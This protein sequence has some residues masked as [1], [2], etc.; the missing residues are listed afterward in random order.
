MPR[1]LWFYSVPRSLLR[2]QKNAAGLLPAARCRFIYRLLLLGCSLCRL[3][4]MAT[5]EVGVEY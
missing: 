4:G 2:S 3:A 5:P 1:R